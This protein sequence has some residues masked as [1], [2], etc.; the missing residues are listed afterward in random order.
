MILTIRLCYTGRHIG[1]TVRPPVITVVAQFGYQAIVDAVCSSYPYQEYVGRAAPA[2]I[3]C[4]G[5]KVDDI[6]FSCELTMAVAAKGALDRSTLDM[7]LVDEAG[8]V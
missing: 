6:F 5:M 3:K 2:A 7:M 8:G 4:V 1:G